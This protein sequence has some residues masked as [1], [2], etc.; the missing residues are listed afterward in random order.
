MFK[1]LLICHNAPAWFV[2]ECSDWYR[3]MEWTGFFSALLLGLQ[4]APTWDMIALKSIIHQKNTFHYIISDHQWSSALFSTYPSPHNHG[5]CKMFL[6]KRLKS[7]KSPMCHFGTQA[8]PFAS[9]YKYVWICHIN[10]E[11]ILNQYIYIYIYKYTHIR[12]SDLRTPSNQQLQKLLFLHWILFVLF[13]HLT[14]HL[15]VFAG[16]PSS[17]SKGMSWMQNSTKPKGST[18]AWILEES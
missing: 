7:H 9:I 17:S 3:A 6:L 2:T 8:S 4:Q 15:S 1:G 13:D 16:F 5:S 10:H 14:I 18:S 12:F 11:Y